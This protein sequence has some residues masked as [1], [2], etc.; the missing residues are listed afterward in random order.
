M[1]TVNT[2]WLN[3]DKITLIQQ[4]KQKKPTKCNSNNNVTGSRVHH[5][6][7]MNL[8]EMDFFSFFKNF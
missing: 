4:I 7:S 1:L 3:Y 2:Q 8:D 6:T 5:S